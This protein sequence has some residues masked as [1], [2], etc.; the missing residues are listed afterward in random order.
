MLGRDDLIARALA[1]PGAW[2][3]E[4]RE[5]GHPGDQSGAA[6]IPVLGGPADEP[7]ASRCAC[8]PDDVEVWRSRYPACFGPAPYLGV[9][10]WNRI[11][12]AGCLVRAA[13]ARQR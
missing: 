13:V 9:G 7:A 10:P 1:Q 3:D 11:R 6:H 2:L 12:L 4:P 5:P 8:Q